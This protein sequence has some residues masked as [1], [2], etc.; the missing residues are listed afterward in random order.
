MP[1]CSRYWTWRPSPAALPCS[2]RMCETRVFGGEESLASAAAELILSRM[3]SALESRGRCIV[4]LAGGLTP[5]ATLRNLADLVNRRNLPVQRALWLF[6]DERC[7][8]MGHPESNEGMARVALLGS[9]HAPEESILSWRAEFGDPVECAARCGEEALKR[10][11]GEPPDV[12]LLGVGQDGHTASLFPGA[13]AV[14]PDGR[15]MPVSPKVPAV[16]FAVLRPEGDWRLTFS[17]PFLA[18]GRSVLFLASG[19][20]K[21]DALRRAV[22]SDPTTP[23][24]WVRGGE[25]FFYVT[26]DCALDKG[27]DLG[28]GV[29]FA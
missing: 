21:K 8:P 7:V 15:R 9:I 29:R 17:A 18:G 10:L 23:A 20:A 1:F 16:S 27:V 13:M 28:G 6:G 25:T 5:K 14:L 11:A 22:T 12:V 2:G 19:G 24:S 3:S 4:V 26:R